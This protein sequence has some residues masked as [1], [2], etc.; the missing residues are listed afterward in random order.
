MERKSE[1]L[2]RA[3]RIVYYHR[4]SGDLKTN[5]AL[6]A[7]REDMEA[8][9]IKAGNAYISLQEENETDKAPDRPGPWGYGKPVSARITAPRP[10]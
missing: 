8:T 1:A 10:K 6:D 9:V 2:F 3:W 4:I 7:A 5:R